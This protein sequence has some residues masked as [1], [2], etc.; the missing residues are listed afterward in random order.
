MEGAV[1]PM[2]ERS[3]SVICDNMARIKMFTVAGPL[4]CNAAQEDRI[5]QLLK[6]RQAWRI[7]PPLVMLAV[8]NTDEKVA[9]E[10][11]QSEDAGDLAR[12]IIVRQ[13]G[14]NQTVGNAINL[15]RQHFDPTADPFTAKRQS[16][17]SLCSIR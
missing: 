6:N 7:E 11:F 14:H 16:H 17:T 13:K 1:Y 3:V 8:H 2:M 4:L 12:Y 9:A 15:F 5:V 10:R